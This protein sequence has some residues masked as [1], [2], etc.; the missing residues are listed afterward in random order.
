MLRITSAAVVGLCLVGF[1]DGASAQLRPDRPYR[2]LFGGGAPT[3]VGQSLAVTGSIGSGWDDNSLG[4]GGNLDSFR[5]S[6]FNRAVRGTSG[7][8]AA[9]LQYGLNL[10]RVGLTAGVSTHAR[11]Y[12]KLD[13]SLVRRDYVHASA[14]VGLFRGLSAHG[15]TTYGP[16][17]V[18][19]IFDQPAIPDAADDLDSVA[20]DATLPSAREHYLS[21]NLGVRMSE[22]IPIS[23]RGSLSGSY[24]VR[25]RR[26]DVPE[27]GVVL[28]EQERPTSRG[29]EYT[30]HTATVAYTHRLSGNLSL[31]AGYRIDQAW[32]ATTADEEERRTTLHFIDAGVHYNRTLSF[33]R[34]TS[35]AFRTGT[36]VIDNP[37]GLGD[38]RLQLTGRAVLTHELGRSWD[39]T[40]TY[41]RGVT[42]SEIWPEPIT[43]D[44]VIA[45]VGGQI[46]RRMQFSASARTARGNSGFNA[47][48]S[49]SFDW[50]AA[51]ASLG[52]ALSRYVNLVGRYSYYMHDFGNAALLAPGIPPDVGRHSGG[53]HLTF[54]APLIQPRNGDATR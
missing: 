26:S 25:Q 24:R 51:G 4:R 6:D 13:P 29:R 14:S 19:R 17:E 22:S 43:Y 41:A 50:V 49:N 10:G 54:W 9:G 44:A 11:Y 45:R 15:S 3:G 48:D 34:R 12:E 32:Y 2:G 52:L 42:L 21:Y 40:L 53:V 8:A 37:T 36:V 46:T 5:P 28:D 47:T 35:V 27:G 39:A 31:R 38:P 7:Y 16:Y 30:G 18:G 20:P 1:P 23:R 33:S